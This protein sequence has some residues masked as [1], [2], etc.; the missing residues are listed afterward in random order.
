METQ[1][2]DISH[3]QQGVVYLG[4][5]IYFSYYF[6][7]FETKKIILFN[8]HTLNHVIKKKSYC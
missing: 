5:I 3:L 4:H 6:V 8:R 1:F 2:V 7:E